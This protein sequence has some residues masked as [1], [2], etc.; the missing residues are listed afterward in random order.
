MRSALAEDGAKLFDTSS[1][2]TPGGRWDLACRHL[3]W[4]FSIPVQYEQV[5]YRHDK[6]SIMAWGWFC[7]GGKWDAP[8]ASDALK[9]TP[10][11]LGVR[12]SLF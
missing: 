1:N 8:L 12:F 2:Q 5:T 9:H 11:R 4:T 10:H 3:P 6:V 7:R